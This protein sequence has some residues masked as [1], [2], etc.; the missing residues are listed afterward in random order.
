[1]IVIGCVFFVAFPFW[2]SSKTLAPR[3]FLALRHLTNRNILAGCA[4]GFFYFGEL[5][6]CVQRIPCSVYRV[7]AH[8]AFSFLL[9]LHPT[10][11]LRVSSSGAK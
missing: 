1:M 2:E 11:L 3:R 4:I 8:L 6:L 10:L 9:H 5:L 7:C